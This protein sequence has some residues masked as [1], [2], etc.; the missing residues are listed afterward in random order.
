MYHFINNKGVFID[1]RNIHNN[2][3]YEIFVES[4]ISFEESEQPIYNQILEQEAIEL[5][6]L[7]NIIKNKNS[8]ILNLSTD[9]VSC[10]FPDG[11]LPFKLKG[12]NIRGYY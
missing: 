3:Y 7:T 12:N 4:K 2:N 11:E 1:S 9:C 5:H 10:V 8:F 6:K